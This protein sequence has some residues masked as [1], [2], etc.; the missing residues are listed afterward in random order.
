[1]IENMTL[2]GNNELNSWVLQSKKDIRSAQIRVV[3]KVNT[4]LLH[5]YWRMGEDICERQK[6]AS[7]AMACLK[8]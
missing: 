3:I 8:N 1:M 7:C 5:L 4:E 6:S 2:A